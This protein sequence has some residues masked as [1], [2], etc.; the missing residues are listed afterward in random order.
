MYREMTAEEKLEYSAAIINAI[1][2]GGIAAS[3]EVVEEYK[4]KLLISE[5][6]IDVEE[7]NEHIV[8]ATEITE[9]T[10][11]I[12]EPKITN[13]F[14]K[15]AS[16]YAS[17]H[18]AAVEEDRNQNLTTQESSNVISHPKT[19]MLTNPNIPSSH[20]DDEDK[21]PAPSPYQDAKV[22]EPGHFNNPN[23][24]L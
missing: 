12:K 23:K 10:P 14:P 19:R 5:G 22:V 3:L 21:R 7:S 20:H 16:I 8:T 9:P 15:E 24:M 2:E 17:E 1:K 18:I 13:E 6:I 11:S 4:K